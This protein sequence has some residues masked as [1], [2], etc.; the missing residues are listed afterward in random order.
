MTE[1]AS[2][3]V[4]VS[5]LNLH[6]H[7]MYRD[8]RKL[9]YDKYNLVVV[10]A[11]HSSI[12]PVNLDEDFVRRCAKEGYLVLMQWA[13]E[14]GCPWSSAVCGAA[15]VGGH[16]HVLQWARESG[17]P[18]NKSTCENA[19]MNGHLG[20]L[21]WVRESGCPWN[22]WTCAFAAQGCSNGRGKVYCFQDGSTCTYAAT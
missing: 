15:A 5:W 19:A 20:V 18:W 14:Q 4:A 17:C 12:R 10:K 6:A 1:E 9:V 21:Q 22:E 13:R 7:G 11:A 8:L 16:L 3:A 2:E